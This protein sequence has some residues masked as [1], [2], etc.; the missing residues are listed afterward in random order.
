MKAGAGGKPACENAFA[1]GLGVGE[2]AV[3]IVRIPGSERV[4]SQL[5]IG[6]SRLVGTM[7]LR[8]SVTLLETAFDMGIRHIDTAPSYGLGHAEHRVGEFLRRR[9]DAVTIT[10]KYGIAA[11]PDASWLAAARLVARPIVNRSRALKQRLQRVMVR[12]NQGTGPSFTVADARLT[13]DRSLRT[14]NV[15]RIDVW[16]LHEAR[17]QDLDEKLLRFMEESVRNGKIGTFG[18]GS[19]ISKIQAVYDRQRT[20]CPVIQYEWNPMEQ[21]DLSPGSFRI[22][23]TVVR[24][25]EPRLSQRIGTDE[26]LYRRWSTEIGADLREPGMIATLLLKAAILGNREG[27]TLFSTKRRQN[28]IK[29]AN[30]VSD[31]SLD[32]PASRLHALLRREGAEFLKPTLY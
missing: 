4:T 1:M 2:L 18:V 5:G 16:L 23:H 21:A 10:T 19:T 30:I 32:L 7:S 24:E 8:E 6:T 17:E 26:E 27:I 12:A 14:L 9:R 22:R 20:Y 28:V 25:W 13:L 3:N 15:E 11:P 29:N 31:S